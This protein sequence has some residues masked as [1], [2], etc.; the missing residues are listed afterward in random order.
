[1]TGMMGWWSLRS[2]RM[3]QDTNC[4]LVV[5]VKAFLTLNI[6]GFLDSL[7]TCYSE[8]KKTIWKL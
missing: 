1:M 2:D 3:L 7:I 6:A 5:A 8:H 4:L